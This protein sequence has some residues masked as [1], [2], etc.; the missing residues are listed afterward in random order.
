MD[1]GNLKN[2]LRDGIREV[3]MKFFNLNLGYL[4][5]DAGEIFHSSLLE[6]EPPQWINFENK[7]KRNILIIV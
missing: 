5:G 1:L 2:L 7:I 4:P 6:F 3:F